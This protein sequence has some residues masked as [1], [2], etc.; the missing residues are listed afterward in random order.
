MGT[1]SIASP[2]ATITATEAITLE[3]TGW[4][5][6][7]SGLVNIPGAS[8]TGD[9]HV[10]TDETEPILP[11]VH[12]S[13]VLPPD[14]N[15][16]GIT[17]NQ[18]ESISETISNDVPL[19]TITV[20]STTL[21]GTYPYTDTFYPATPYYTSTIS[22]LGG[23]AVEVGLTIVPVQYRQST[24][25]TRIW[26]R[27]VFE[28]EYEMDDGALSAD[29]DNDTLLN[30]WESGYGLDPN[31][32]SGD[33]GAGGD[34]DGDG[35]T[36]LQER[37]LGTNPLDPDTDHDG[38]NDGQEVQDETDPLNPGSRFSHL[39]LPLLLRN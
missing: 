11:I 20:L 27:S 30:Y 5:T 9:Y 24:H 33:Q 16:V 26:T 34:P 25:E 4:Y 8:Y 22:T 38:S 31:D 17:W 32:D 37:D 15:I 12:A 6:D 7:S 35:L 21:T 3:I 19:A 29:N 28:I 36:N 39:Y 2:S 18:T 1:Q 23:G 13:H 10:D 14:A